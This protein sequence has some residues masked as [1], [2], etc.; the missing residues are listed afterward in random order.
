[1]LTILTPTPAHGGQ[2]QYCYK[3]SK[4]H[5]AQPWPSQGDAAGQREEGE[6]GISHT[7]WRV[8]P[9]H[10]DGVHWSAVLIPSCCH[11]EGE[12]R[13]SEPA[14]ACR[15]GLIWFIEPGNLRKSELWAVLCKP[16][17][18]KKEAVVMDAK[19]LLSCGEKCLWIP[20]WRDISA[21]PVTRYYPAQ[22]LAFRNAHQW[23]WKFQPHVKSL[24]WIFHPLSQQGSVPHSWNAKMV[25][26]SHSLS[27]SGCRL[28]ISCR[29]LSR[30]ALPNYA[31]P[32]SICTYP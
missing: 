27:S 32:K 8:R 13:S 23:W 25:V 2:Q 9:A 6:S 14:A 17:Q 18:V 5:L 21:L 30:V 10:T 15:D 24:T 19:N 22:G 28:G 3:E 4:Q 31:G 16:L 7:K 11:G 20:M 26:K 1:M 12:E 29:T